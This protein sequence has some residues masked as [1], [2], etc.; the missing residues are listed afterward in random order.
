MFLHATLL[1]EHLS[2]TL[3]LGYLEALALTLAV[4]IPVV[5]WVLRRSPWRR[6]LPAVLIANLVSHPALH[7]ALPQILPPSPPGPFVLV[8]ELSVFA[9]EAAFYAVWVRPRPWPL[10]MAA[11]A[12]ANLTSFAAGLLMLPGSP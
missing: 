7:F 4:E 6:Y 2:G 8:G 10:A 11:S 5:A 1:A 3:L 9:F 12:A